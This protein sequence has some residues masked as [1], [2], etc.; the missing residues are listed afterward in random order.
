MIFSSVAMC[1]TTAEPRPIT[2]WRTVVHH[3]GGGQPFA[4]YI[5]SIPPCASLNTVLLEHFS[6]LQCDPSPETCAI[7]N[8]PTWRREGRYHTHRF[9]LVMSNMKAHPAVTAVVVVDVDEVVEGP[10]VVKVHLVHKLIVLAAVGVFV[11]S[12]DVGRG[13]SRGVRGRRSGGRTQ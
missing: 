8:I 4:R 12:V 10:F 13:R 5:I 9:Q 1:S 6:V 3:R 7:A 11:G 2:T